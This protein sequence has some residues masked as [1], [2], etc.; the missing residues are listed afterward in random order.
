MPPFTLFVEE[1]SASKKNCQEKDGTWPERWCSFWPSPSFFPDAQRLLFAAPGASK[2]GVLVPASRGSFTR[3]DFVSAYG[4][5]AGEW[6]GAENRTYEVLL[7]FSG[8]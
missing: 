2:T 5:V 7:H 3:G 1:T 4:L 8:H 6:P